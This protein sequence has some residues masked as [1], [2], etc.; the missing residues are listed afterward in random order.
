MREWHQNNITLVEEDKGEL[1]LYVT[2]E[3]IRFGLQELALLPEEI[4][5]IKEVIEQYL[6]KD[7]NNRAK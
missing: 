3:T 7:I 2:D 1:T 6:S 4:L 5:R